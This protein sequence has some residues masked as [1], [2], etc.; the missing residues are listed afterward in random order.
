MKTYRIDPAQRDLL[1]RNLSVKLSTTLAAMMLAVIVVAGL[2]VWQMPAM[3]TTTNM[4]IMLAAIAALGGIV[5]YRMWGQVRD[6]QRGLDSLQIGISD[7]RITRRQV[8]LP[9]LT[10]L[11]S[12][13]MLLQETEAGILVV[14]KERTKY[15]WAPAQLAGFEDVRAALGRWQAIHKAPPQ[16]GGEK[17]GL[18]T[19]AWATGTA[20]CMGVLLFASDPRM[21]IAAGV[22]TLAIYLFIYR[23]L[24][25]QRGIDTRFRRT[26]S[27]VFLF[28][29]VVVAAKVL[30]ALSPLMTGK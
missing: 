17:T 22:A 11:R 27:G 6:Y 1:V 25:A 9:D 13:V 20:L 7:D 23:L 16:P 15:L 30:M 8:R 2:I 4:L 18:L 5:G 3:S 29:V 14:A 19:A 28:L 10:I 12:E 26:Y 21:V 24:S